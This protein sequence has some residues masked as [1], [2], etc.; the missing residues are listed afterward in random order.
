MI[1]YNI[2]PIIRF[3]T[4]NSNIQPTITHIFNNHLLWASS[5]QALLSTSLIVLLLSHINVT[6]TLSSLSSYNCSFSWW[7]FCDVASFKINLYLYLY[8][9]PPTIHFHMLNYYVQRLYVKLHRILYSNKILISSSKSSSRNWTKL[10]F[11][12]K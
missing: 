4:L 6:G 10:A 9:L 11:E 12:Y 2:K 8:K 5:T 1:R 7:F 3:H